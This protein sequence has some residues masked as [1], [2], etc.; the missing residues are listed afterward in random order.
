MGNNDL[1]GLDKYQP[2]P[3]MDRFP[4]APYEPEDS[5]G[6]LTIE[7]RESLCAA[8]EQLATDLDTARAEFAFMVREFLEM[9]GDRPPPTSLLRERGCSPVDEG[10]VYTKIGTLV[11]YCELLKGAARQ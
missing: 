1:D 5:D 8:L 6:E 11:S 10:Y 7:Q 3:L 2:L 4:G 9:P